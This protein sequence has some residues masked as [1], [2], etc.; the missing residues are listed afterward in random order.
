MKK[1]FL[2]VVCCF[3]ALCSFGQSQITD[4]GLIYSEGGFKI[5]K[6]GDQNMGYSSGLYSNDGKV[7]V[8]MVENHRNDGFLIAYGTEVIA[9]NTFRNGWMVRIPSTVKYID[10]GAFSGMKDGSTCDYLIYIDD[11]KTKQIM[12]DDAAAVSKVNVDENAKEVARFNLQ[13][14]KLSKP[15]KGINIVQL[16]NHT[17][18]KVLVK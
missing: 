8:M 7:L 2:F 17:A 18:K 6:V 11:I 13:G 5:I 3:T 12:A 15:D 1:F 14:Q 9:K 4:K 16:A 10:P